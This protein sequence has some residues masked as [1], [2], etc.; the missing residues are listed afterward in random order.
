MQPRPALLCSPGM[1]FCTVGPRGKRWM[2][3]GGGYRSQL[4]ANLFNAKKNYT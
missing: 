3:P 4:G 1:G 2:H